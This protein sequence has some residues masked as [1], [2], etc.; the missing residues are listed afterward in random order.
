MAIAPIRQI[1][2]GQPWR[3][4]MC[5]HPPESFRLLFGPYHSPKCRVG[6][7]LDCEARGRTV[8]IGGIT[9]ATIRGPLRRRRENGRS[10]SAGIWSQPSRSNP[11]QPSPTIGAFPPSPS[12]LGGGRWEFRQTTWGVYA[13]GGI[14]SPSV[15]RRPFG[16]IQSQNECI[17]IQTRAQSSILGRCPSGCQKPKSQAWKQAM[18]QRM[19]EQWAKTS[20]RIRS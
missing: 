13:S 12:G 7:S 14:T 17:T 1:L 3:C 19:K 5:H 20:G 10:F 8:V 9:D 11:R 2:P 18:S 4:L 16:R 15:A 6:S